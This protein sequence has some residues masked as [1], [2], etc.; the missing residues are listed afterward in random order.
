MNLEGRRVLI[1][2]DEP[3]ND[4]AI[5]RH[6]ATPVLRTTRRS[7]WRR[8]ARSEP[9]S[10]R[11]RRRPSRACARIPRRPRAF[12]QHRL[13]RARMPRPSATRPPLERR[14]EASLDHRWR[15]RKRIAEETRIPSGFTADVN[16]HMIVDLAGS[17]PPSPGATRACVVRSPG[18]V[19]AV[20]ALL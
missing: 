9:E 10:M 11:H 8:R 1:L 18:V 5:A 12:A 19:L 20:P 7:K 14:V 13:I 4:D 3:T 6:D 2:I 15:R 17:L 16:A